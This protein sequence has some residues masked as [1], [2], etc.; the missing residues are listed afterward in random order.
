MTFKKYNKDRQNKNT[1]F[2]LITDN[3]QP[4]FPGKPEYQHLKAEC[5]QSRITQHTATL[6]DNIFTNDFEQIESIVST[7]LY[8]LIFL[9]TFLFLT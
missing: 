8:L 2:Y 9:I 1:C 5:S 6:I 7:D 3:F 4:D